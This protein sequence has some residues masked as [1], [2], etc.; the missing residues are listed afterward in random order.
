MRAAFDI[1]ILDPFEVDIPYI[2]D[3]NMRTTAS[4]N[5]DS[6]LL[7]SESTLHDD[8]PKTH[9]FDIDI[10]DVILSA[11]GG[12]PTGWSGSRLLRAR[13][14]MSPFSPMAP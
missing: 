2:P 10:L 3:V 11:I 13:A 8:T 5:F 1:Y 7:D 9:L 4:D 14:S 12:L 6:F